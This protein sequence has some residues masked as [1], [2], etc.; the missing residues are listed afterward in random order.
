MN[1]G[2]ERPS[3]DTL[4]LYSELN[5]RLIKSAKLNHISIRKALH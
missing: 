1:K 3:S 2:K 5:N 4:F